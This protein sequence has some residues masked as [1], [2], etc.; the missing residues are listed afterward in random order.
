VLGNYTSIIDTG[1][2]GGIGVPMDGDVLRA[3]IKGNIIT[4]FKNGVAQKMVDVTPAGPVWPDGQP[5]MGFW[6]VDSST[7]Q[8]YGWKKFEA[9]IL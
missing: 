9:G 8:N 1:D 5:G 2:A 3:E 4:I 7:P 6:P